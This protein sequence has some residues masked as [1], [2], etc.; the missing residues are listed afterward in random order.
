MTFSSLCDFIEAWEWERVVVILLGWV[1]QLLTA[2]K[3]GQEKILV[4][5]K[6]MIS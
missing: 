6:K 4:P 1:D 2:K 3:K 5:L